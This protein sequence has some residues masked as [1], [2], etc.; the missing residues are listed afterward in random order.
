LEFKFVRKAATVEEGVVFER[1]QDCAPLTNFG[2]FNDPN[3]HSLVQSGDGFEV[4][5]IDD[6]KYPLP[7]EGFFRITA[8][9]TVATMAFAPSSNHAAAPIPSSPHGC[10]LRRTNPP[11]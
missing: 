5:T 10:S 1:S 11:A 9:L 4:Q 6:K 7:L 3:T 8:A 2:V